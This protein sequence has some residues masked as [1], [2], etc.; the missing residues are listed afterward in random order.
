MKNLYQLTTR[1]LGDYYVLANDPT[2]AQDALKRIFND[3][4][5][6]STDDRRI[7]NIKWI[8]EAFDRSLADEK[9]PFLS[10]DSQRLFIVQ[11]WQ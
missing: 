11:N 1:G 3:Q 10:N 8:A 4:K 6:G 2:E 5:Y 7:L 9:K